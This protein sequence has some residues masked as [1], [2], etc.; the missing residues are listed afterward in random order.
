MKASQTAISQDE[1]K[2]LLVSLGFSPSFI[3]ELENSPDK[4][5]DTPLELGN[6]ERLTIEQIFD[7][8]RVIIKPQT[9]YLNT[10]IS[11]D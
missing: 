1:K 10:L 4:T 9:D 8:E 6:L 7:P 5:S 11:V 3:E 2:S